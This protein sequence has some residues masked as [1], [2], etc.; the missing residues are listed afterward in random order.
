M[1][2]PKQTQIIPNAVPVVHWGVLFVHENVVSVYGPGDE[3]KAFAE[4]T[5]ESWANT[6]YPAELVSQTIL[7]WTN[8]TD[9]KITLVQ[10]ILNARSDPKGVMVL[11]DWLV[12]NGLDET[13]STKTGLAKQ[14]PVIKEMRRIGSIAGALEA[15]TRWLEAHGYEGLRLTSDEA[16]ALLREK[17]GE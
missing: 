14:V 2:E 7:P 16:I 4:A 17:L 10:N 8:V 3:A 12:N 1:I 13:G 9:N 6:D 11:R 15:L 5:V